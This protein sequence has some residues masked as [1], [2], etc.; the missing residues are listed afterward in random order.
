MALEMVKIMSGLEMDDIDNFV[1]SA[2][3][4]VGNIIS[5]NALTI[6]TKGNYK[7]D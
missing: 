6:L 2:L 1:S 5:D 7:C 4:E 3:G